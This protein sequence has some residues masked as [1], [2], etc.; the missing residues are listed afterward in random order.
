VAS[1][2]QPNLKPVAKVDDNSGTGL[3]QIKIISKETGNRSYLS[4]NR[5]QFLETN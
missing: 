2:S 5:T 4:G 1:L 3:S